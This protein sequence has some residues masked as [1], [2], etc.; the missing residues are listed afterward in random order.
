[1]RPPLRLFAPDGLIHHGPH[2][3]SHINCSSV[4]VKGPPQRASRADGK[5]SPLPPRF[6]AAR[7]VR[8]LSFSKQALN[9]TASRAGMVRRPAEVRCAARTSLEALGQGHGEPPAPGGAHGGAHGG[10]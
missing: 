2:N 6:M 9:T 4:V 1:M 5:R 7:F 3:S 8:R 10:A